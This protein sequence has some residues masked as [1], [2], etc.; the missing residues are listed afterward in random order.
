MSAGRSPTRAQIRRRRLAALAVLAILAA[1]IVALL[2]G[3]GSSAG[4]AGTLHRGGYRLVHIEAKSKAVPGHRL[5]VNVI[6]PPQPGPRGK[7]P[8]LIYLHGRGGYEGTFNDAVL[9]GLPALHGRGPIVA[10]PAGGVHGY[11]HDRAAGRWEDWVM[12]EALPLVERRFGIDP[13]RIAIG[14]ISMGGFGALDIAL[15]NPGR[16]CAVGAHSPALWFEAGETAPGA[17]E[18]AADFER[19]DVVRAVEENPDAFGKAHVWVDYGEEDDFLP[20]DDGFVA[21]LAGGDGDITVHS[22]PG[23]HEGSYWGKHWPDYQRWY[24]RAL[25]HCG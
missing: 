16:F 17:F 2:A 18:D 11:W 4:P 22:W 23:G 25:A 6:V 1:A 7:R 10:F 3:S 12:D 20:Y 5:G 14:G 13:K 9:R 15:H 8:L 21:A 19:N 24:V